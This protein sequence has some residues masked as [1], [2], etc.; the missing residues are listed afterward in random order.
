MLEKEK[1]L[2]YK[3]FQKYMEFLLWLSGLRTRD[4]VHKDMGSTSGL[5]QWVQD[6]VLPQDVPW[7]PLC[8]G[9]GIGLQ[10]QLQFDH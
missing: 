3:V 10:L 4:N 7:I 5:A 9:C 8:H 6:L 1:K 2:P